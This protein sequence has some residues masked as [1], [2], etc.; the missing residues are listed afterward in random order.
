MQLQLE[1]EAQCSD[2]NAAVLRKRNLPPTGRKGFFEAGCLR[3]SPLG[4]FFVTVLEEEARLGRKGGVMEQEESN[5]GASKGQG[6][7]SCG[8][9]KEGEERREKEEKR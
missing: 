5:F 8:V 7:A 1:L 9:E 2:G 6:T 3:A 4:R